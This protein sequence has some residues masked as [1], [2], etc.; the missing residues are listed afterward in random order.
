MITSSLKYIDLYKKLH[1]NLATAIDYI[2]QTDFLQM[3]PGRYEIAGE[4]VFAIV[5]EYQTKPP[6]EC[7][8]ESHRMY[9]DIQLMITGK[10]RFGYA[11]LHHHIPTTPFRADNDVAFYSIHEDDMNFVDLGPGDFIIFF[12]SDIHQPEL[13]INQPAPVKKVVIKVN[14]GD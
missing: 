5:N 13:M 6:Q 11:P 4:D 12:P 10:E 14:T 7:D 3:S 9:T 1:H 8:P 2:H